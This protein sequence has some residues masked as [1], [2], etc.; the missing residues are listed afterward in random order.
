ML[1]IYVTADLSSPKVTSQALD[2]VIDFIDRQSELFYAVF[3]LI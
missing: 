2:T 1:A 3:T